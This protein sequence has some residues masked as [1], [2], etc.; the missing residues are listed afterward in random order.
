MNIVICGGGTAGWLSA[1]IIANSQPYKHRITVIES[2]SIGIV[3]AGEASSGLLYDLLSGNLFQNDRLS[4]RKPFNFDIEDFMEKVHGTPKYALKHVNWAK[5]KGSYLAPIFGPETTK[6]TPDILFNYVISEYGLD[7]AYL[8]SHLGHSYELNRMPNESGH[9]FQ[10]DAFK[11][12]E[13]MK[14]YMQKNSNMIHIDSKIEDVKLSPSGNIEQLILSNGE[15]V[16][17]D[18]FIDC[19]GFSRI[20]AKKLDIGWTSYKDVLPVDR[21]MP[22][23]MKYDMKSKEKIEPITTAQAL[24]SGWMWNTP[25]KHRKGC[26]YVYSSE[27]LTEDQAQY[28]VEKVLGTSIEPIK[29]LKF[30]SGRL[31]LSWK[32]NCIVAGLANSF[33]EPLEATSIHATIMQIFTFCQEYLTED[34][35]S[36]A[37]ESNISR[38]NKNVSEMYDYYKDFIVFHYQGGRD[39]SEFWKHIKEDKLTTPVVQEYIDRSKS[40]IPGTLHF[41]DY[42]GVDGLWKWTLAGLGFIT[43]EQ[44]KK[45]L[46]MFRSYEYAKEYYESFSNFQTYNL[47]AQEKPFEIFPIYSQDSRG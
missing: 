19:T 34:V 11:V 23:L 41:M 6:R 46:E 45:E 2:S 3:G 43:P 31:N 35:A 16:D 38:Y 21:A 26:G 24:S 30:E 36:T 27:F 15:T 14:N 20:L 28:E 9:G 32:N 29:H 10:F 1:F 25:L 42:W 12:G 47:A 33:I 7:K 8:S 37:T 22:F 4:E 5:E 40:R 17:G 39:D 13:Y 18:F 44:A